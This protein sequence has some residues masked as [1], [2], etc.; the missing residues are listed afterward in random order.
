MLH[1]PTNR[2]A[3]EYRPGE[4]VGQ[5]YNRMVKHGRKL[6]PRIQEHS[7]VT[8]Q[9]CP[10][11]TTIRHLLTKGQWRMCCAKFVERKEILR[12]RTSVK[13]IQEIKAELRGDANHT[14]SHFWFRE[15][16]VRC[17]NLS[18]VMRVTA[19]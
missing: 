1:N 16:W 13:Q 12:D 15:K 4:T 8:S 11:C 10:R 17:L 19:A 6:D 7:E 14:S 9:A 18:I 2:S 3:F 5:R